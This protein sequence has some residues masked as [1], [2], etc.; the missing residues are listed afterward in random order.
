MR[1]IQRRTPQLIRFSFHTPS[2]GFHGLIFFHSRIEEKRIRTHE[3]YASETRSA[4]HK[5]RLFEI[6]AK[7][8]RT[9][10]KE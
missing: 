4:L 8:R 1:R 5:A 6:E 10:P 2:I 3:R 9:E 7:N